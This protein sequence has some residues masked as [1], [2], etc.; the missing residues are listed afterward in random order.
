MNDWATSPWATNNA[1]PSLSPAPPALAK[2]SP[3]QAALGSGYFDGFSNEAGWAD[4][5]T[6]GAGAIGGAENV[7]GLQSP[8]PIASPGRVANGKGNRYIRPILSVWD[9][10]EPEENDLEAVGAAPEQLGEVLALG[11]T[12]DTDGVVVA[13]GIPGAL[14]DQWNTAGIVE[15]GLR[16]DMEDSSRGDP[17]KN[18]TLHTPQIEV[19]QAQ[20]MDGITHTEQDQSGPAFGADLPIHDGVTPNPAAVGVYEQD[21]TPPPPK[22]PHSKI[23]FPVDPDL[24]AKFLKRVTNAVDLELP[25]LDTI[26][27]TS[28]QRKAQHRLTRPYTLRQYSLG[29]FENYRRVTWGTST[30]HDEVINI[31]GK[32]IAKDRASGGGMFDATLANR[33]GNFS[34]GSEGKRDTQNP[35]VSASSILLPKIAAPSGFNWSSSSMVPLSPRKLG[36]IDVDAPRAS[37]DIKQM[38]PRQRR[39]P[40]RRKPRVV[41]GKALV[42][43]RS[44]SIMNGAWT[45]SFDDVI[46]P[47]NGATSPLAQASVDEPS[48]NHSAA[49]VEDD[50]GIFEENT[51]VDTVFEDFVIAPP[52]AISSPISMDNVSQDSLQVDDEPS[53]DGGQTHMQR[54]RSISE[55]TTPANEVTFP[56]VQGTLPSLYTDELGSPSMLHTERASPTKETTEDQ[57]LV[58]EQSED[59]DDFDDFD[60]FESAPPL[61]YT[62]MPDELQPTHDEESPLSHQAST[63]ETGTSLQRGFQDDNDMG[64]PTARSLYHERAIETAP[65]DFSAFESSL[66]PSV[67]SVDSQADVN[68]SPAASKFEPGA[69]GAIHPGTIIDSTERPKEVEVHNEELHGVTTAAHKA[70]VT[71]GEP[72][73]RSSSPVLASFEPSVATQ[74]SLPSSPSLH[75][76]PNSHET[77]SA[78]DD[79]SIFETSADEPA[80]NSLAASHAASMNRD[81]HDLTPT[82]TSL[83]HSKHPGPR[84]EDDDDDFGAFEDAVSPIASATDMAW[85]SLAPPALPPP[86]TSWNMQNRYSVPL[87]AQTLSFAPLVPDLAMPRS[88]TAPPVNLFPAPSSQPV[89]STIPLLLSATAAPVRPS[90]ALVLP[91]LSAEMEEISKPAHSSRNTQIMPSKH[92]TG[93]LVQKPPQSLNSTKTKTNQP[94]INSTPRPPRTTA[95]PRHDAGSAILGVL[96][97]LDAEDEAQDD[98]TTADDSFG[99]WSGES[100]IDVESAALASEKEVKRLRREEWVGERPGEKGMGRSGTGLGHGEGEV[101]QAAVQRVVDGLPDWGYLL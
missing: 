54:P 67:P 78:F 33:S 19:L 14:E 100:G 22:F 96:A 43:P 56:S 60:A 68:S 21:S 20:D 40:I 17:S 3:A 47:Q 26:I 9:T 38:Q 13:N 39:T 83:D 16:I 12:G 86:S 10:Q 45:D 85:P 71:E 80:P 82:P 95:N 50:F 23:D 55:T 44:P 69:D 81:T 36:E 48:M 25:V 97:F 79:F 8:R 91:S 52:P 75:S 37:E 63:F 7:V 65:D 64:K 35:E 2:T 18:G 4:A 73:P 84:P 46:S 15:N 41:S 6:S 93:S 61:D 57:S 74:E 99:A 72:S 51:E 59:L 34:W 94:D 88:S 5:V 66:P 58:V 31:V 98:A 92:A 32:W 87:S 30:I 76:E 29:E 49:A 1:T 70:S 27:T 77:F 42:S 90:S 62:D 53:S 11:R 89:K 101:D 28:S 24:L